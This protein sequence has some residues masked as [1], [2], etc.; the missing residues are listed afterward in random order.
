M[1]FDPCD[2]IGIRPDLAEISSVGAREQIARLK[3]VDM[4]V[5]ITGQDE[6]AGA[7]DPAGPDGN[8]GF[9]AASDTFDFVTV[10]DED[11]VFD[12]PAVRGVDDGSAYE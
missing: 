1:R 3:E 12:N 9:F 10:N 2:F 8:T 5:D 11:S 4:S 7:I 6:F